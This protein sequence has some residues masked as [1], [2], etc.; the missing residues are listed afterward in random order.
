MEVLGTLFWKLLAVAKDAVTRRTLSR[1]EVKS[2]TASFLRYPAKAL[3]V[4]I[5]APFLAYRVA[6][7]AEDPWRRRIAAVGLILSVLAAYAAGTTLGT[8]VVALFIASHMG[9][10]VAIGFVLGVGLSVVFSAVL[11]LIAMNATATLAL[12]ISDQR[13]V[14][15]IRAIS[16]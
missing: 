11:G 15:Y 6:T 3:A 16:R 5:T 1:S 2:T 7:L 13:V 12:K 10:L 14:D 8:L 4:F 9:V